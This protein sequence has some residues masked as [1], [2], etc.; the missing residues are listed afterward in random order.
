MRRPSWLSR[1]PRLD[2]RRLV[3]LG[4][5]FLAAVGTLGFLE[6][7]EEVDEEGLRGFDESLLLAFRSPEDPAR[8]RGPSWEPE[9]VRDLTALGGV[10][11]LTLVVGLFAGFLLL[12]G[13]WRL[14][15]LLVAAVAGGTLLT[16]GLK[17]LYGRVRP[18]VVPH[19]MQEASASFPSGHS[20]LS[21][22]VYL[23]LGSILATP[24]RR[25]AVRVFIFS[26]A[27]LVSLAVGATRVLLGVHYP[28]DVLAGWCVGIAWAALCWAAALLLGRRGR[29]GS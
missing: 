1:L 20:A 27:L 10:A 17:F 4:A 11:V 12:E 24:Q 28:S 2:R 8:L 6:L 7:A 26:A 19:L 29:G 9:L 13:R 25:P 14:A 23:T 18:E 5:L 15:L 21:A 16:Q 22:V 3:L